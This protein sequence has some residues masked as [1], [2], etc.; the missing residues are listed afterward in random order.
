MLFYGHE[1]PLQSSH[2]HILLALMHFFQAVASAGSSFH[3]GTEF[4][5]TVLFGV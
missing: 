4:L 2:S 1:F 3:E 5:K